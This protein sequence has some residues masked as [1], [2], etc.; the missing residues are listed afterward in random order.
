V[1]SRRSASL[2]VFLLVAVSTGCRPGSKPVAGATLVGRE[3][4]VSCHAAE[5]MAWRGSRHDRAMQPVDSSTV[6]GDF[7]NATF[8]YTTGVL[9]TFFRRDGG[10]WVRTDGPDGALTEYPIAYTF[11]VYP[12][13]QYLIAFPGGRY[14]AL[15][16]VWDTRPKAE[17]GQRWY[18]LYP[19]EKVDFR[20]PLHWTGP[21]Q[22]WNHMCAEC[23]ST[24]V[25]K[26][27]DP[28]SDTFNTT[29]SEIDVSCEACHGA[30]S[31]H[32]EWAAPERVSRRDRD[33]TMGLEVRLPKPVPGGWVFDAG[34]PIARRDRPIGAGADVETCGRCH[35]RSSVLWAP[36]RHGESLDQSHRVSLLDDPLYE[37][38]GQ[39]RDEVYEYGSFL[40]SRMYRAGVTCSDCHDPHRGG[41]R[42]TGNGVCAGC[43][44]PTKYDAVTHHR[45][46][47]GSNGAQCVSCHMPARTYMGVDARRDHSFSRPR[48]DLSVSLGTPNACADCHRDR[49]AAWAAEQLAGW[50]GPP[51]TIRAQYARAIRAGRDGAPGAAD[52]L[53]FIARDTA[54]TAI[55]RATAVSL[56]PAN[57]GARTLGALQ[58]ALADPSQLVRRA[59]VEAIEG[60]SPEMRLRMGVP[61]L[62]D[63]SRAV[64]LAAV[65]ALA[66]VPAAQW[67]PDDRRTFEAAAAEYRSSQ[68]VNADRAEAH[69]NLGNLARELGQMDTAA[70]EFRTAIRLWPKFTSAWIQL[71]EL[72]RA[73]GGE[74]V[75]DSVLQAGLAVNPES[76]ELHHAVG[77]SLVRQHRATEAVAELGMAARLR[78]EFAR[79]AFV[80]GVA[81]HDTGDPARGL[82]ILRAALRQHPW[83]RDLLQGV[84][85]FS[86]EAGDRPTARDAA[87]RLLQLSPDDP[88]LRRQLDALKP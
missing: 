49:S 12:L 57:P 16:V 21:L 75:T 82:A 6:L 34:A 41:T 28:A 64:R 59:A 83:D 56:M 65:S 46:A 63:P 78:P 23:H 47:P 38:D 29:W 35:A 43:H 84:L 50:F 2:Y 76:A 24:G 36:Y 20:D 45:H 72:A 81:V 52:L 25:R 18:H 86:M 27:Y 19:D 31:R 48:P 77:L 62:T 40:Q 61:M 69:A 88:A 3:A 30:G 10:Y 33:S 11:G 54:S 44:L 1:T 5:D 42:V 71:A 17:G 22:S 68:M 80:H 66:S 73:S 60:V 87:S 39:Q 55:R 14:Q 8:R 13:Q 4:C 85:S 79:Y 7:A 26:S 53:L 70:A 32:L 67:T 15:T 9:T 74:T 37:A 58:L 51:D